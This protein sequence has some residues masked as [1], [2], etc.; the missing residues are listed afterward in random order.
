[1]SIFEIAMLFCF[2]FA[3]PFSI[4]KSYKSGTNSG[5]SLIFLYI[6]FL[7]YLAGIVHKILYSY[8]PV[9]IL[10]IINGLMVL[11]DIMLYY[12]NTK[13]DVRASS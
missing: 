12:R 10:Y 2:G 3:W 5:K 7:G 11:T 9:I 1:M 8:D 6:V 13:L 4:C